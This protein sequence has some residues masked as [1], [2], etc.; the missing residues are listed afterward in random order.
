[1]ILNK[2]ELLIVNGGSFI[3]KHYLIVNLGKIIYKLIKNT[4][5]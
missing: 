5:K 4:I 3:I 2:D 1:M